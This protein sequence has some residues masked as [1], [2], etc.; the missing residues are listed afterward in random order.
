MSAKRW[1]EPMPDRR[2]FATAGPGDII[3]ERE[4][5]RLAFIALLQRLSPRERA[6]LVLR[7]ILKFSARETAEI[8]DSTVAAANSA[9]QRARASLAADRPRPADVLD[10]EGPEQR[11][12]LAR[13]VAAFE[14]HDVAAMTALLREDAITSMPPFTWWLRGGERIAALMAFSDVCAEDRLLVVIGSQTAR[15][16]ASLRG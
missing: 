13:Y 6:I 5:V 7:D 1:V 9:L 3:A 14:S 10:P 4:T 12:L 2:L 8:L 11:E 16:L 15:R